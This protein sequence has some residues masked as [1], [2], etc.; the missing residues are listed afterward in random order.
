VPGISGAE[1]EEKGKRVRELLSHIDSDPAHIFAWK[2]TTFLR[3]VVSKLNQQ[4]N[5]GILI[6]RWTL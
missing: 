2:A 3:Q 6:W 4:L 5:I 1:G